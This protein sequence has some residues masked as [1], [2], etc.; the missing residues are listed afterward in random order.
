MFEGLKSATKTKIAAQYK[1]AEN[2]FLHWLL[3]LSCIRNI[4]AHHSWLWNRQLGV[5][6]VMIPHGWIHRQSPRPDRTY[7]VAVMM[8]HLLSVIARGGSWRKRLVSLLELHPNVSLS[9]MGFPDDWKNIT[10]WK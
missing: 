3:V 4:T 5:Q 10:P 2:P 7:C 8:Q 1:L 6:A 9:A